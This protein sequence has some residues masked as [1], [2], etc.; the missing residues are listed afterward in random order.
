M[1]RDAFLRRVGGA[2]RLAELPDVPDADPGLLVPD[3][4]VVDLVGRF[5]AALS[6][7]G[8]ELHRGDPAATAVGVAAAH[9]ATSY[10]S[11]DDAFLPPGVGTAL[12]GAG[13]RRLETV[14]PPDRRQE[15]QQ[16][17]HDV[18][19]GVTGAEAGLAESGSIV[20]RSGPG[21]PRMAS[22]IPTVHLAFLRPADI[23]RS[24]AHWASLHAGTIGDAANVVVITGVSRTGDI[25]MRLNTGVHGPAQ[26][27]VALV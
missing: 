11:W 22:V 20:V 19:M 8:G 27:H 23:H 18:A 2:V 26:V 24:L 1:E 4:E 5:E 6:D 14:V 25:E 7:V 15:H 3:L 9:G 12:A 13:L 16:L 17:Y 10:L 21:R